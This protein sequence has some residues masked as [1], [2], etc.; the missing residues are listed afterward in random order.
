M[1]KNMSADRKARILAG[2]YRSSWGTSMVTQAI[3]AALEIFMLIYTRVNPALFG[4]YMAVYRRFY[5]GLLSAAAAYILLNIAIKRDLEHRYSWLNVA[6]PLYAALYFAWALGITYFDAVKYGVADPTV[7]MTFSLTVPLSFFLFP[8]IYVVIVAASDV[9]M[10][11][12]MLTVSGSIG[13]LINL[14]IFI[15]FQLVLGISFLLLKMNLAERIISERENAE[16]DVLTGFANRRAYEKEIKRIA[17]E[18]AHGALVYLAIDIN[19]LKEVND[20]HGH[21][22]G[23]RLIIGAANCI[24]QCFGSR[25]KLYR[26]GGDE[27]AVLF[28]ATDGELDG[29]LSEYEGRM[30]AWSEQNGMTLTTAYGCASHAEYPNADITGLARMA[31]RR[32]YEAKAAYYHDSGRDRRRYIPAGR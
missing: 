16:I 13:P 24:E 20:S 9:F 11:Y 23:D 10:F 17:H 7:F 31:D 6:N 4:Q 25:G 12:M 2:I 3:V 27:F 32:M 22:A 28:T 14:S 30:A 5:I 21:E 29:L 26:I 18:S 19:E 8:A 15:I 1:K